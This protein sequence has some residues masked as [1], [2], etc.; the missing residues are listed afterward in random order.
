MSHGAGVVAA[1]ESSQLGVVTVSKSTGPG[2]I[3]NSL[4]TDYLSIVNL[5]VV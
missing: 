4:L 5:C 2:R 3:I 1:Y